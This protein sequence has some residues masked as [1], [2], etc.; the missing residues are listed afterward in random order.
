MN[1]RCSTN[2]GKSRVWVPYYGENSQYFVWGQTWLVFQNGQLV[3]RS[4]NTG[5]FSIKNSRFI[6]LSFKL[7]IELFVSKLAVILF[8]VLT[9][10]NFFSWQNDQ[11][12]N[13]R[14]DWKIADQNGPK[15]PTKMNLVPF[16]L[17]GQQCIN[18]KILEL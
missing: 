16:D 3:N 4:Q 10:T 5:F 9:M 1:Q 17:W 6:L 12:S 11:L 14:F 13:F 18:L 8:G 15:W 2:I 7:L